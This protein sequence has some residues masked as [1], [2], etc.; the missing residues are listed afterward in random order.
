VE[1]GGFDEPWVAA[2]SH[3]AG[4]LT[5]DDATGVMDELFGQYGGG[6]QIVSGCSDGSGNGCDAGPV[7]GAGG[8]GIEAWRQV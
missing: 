4:V 6:R 7:L 1:R 8:R 5:G 2:V 3:N